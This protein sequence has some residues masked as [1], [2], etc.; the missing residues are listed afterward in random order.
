MVFSIVIFL[1]ETV[2]V[3]YLDLSAS[4][5]FPY[6]SWLVVLTVI[7]GLMSFF[8]VVVYIFCVLYIVA[9]DVVL[10]RGISVILL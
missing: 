6:F 2:W 5:E 4:D 8:L 1:G 9:W 7:F 10:I 3:L